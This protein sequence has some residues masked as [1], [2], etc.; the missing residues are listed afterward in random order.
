MLNFQERNSKERLKGNRNLIWFHLK[1]CYFKLNM[2]RHYILQSNCPRMRKPRVNQVARSG[3]SRAGTRT[4]QVAE[5]TFEPGTGPK[6][7]NRRSPQE[8]RAHLA[9]WEVSFRPQE[10]FPVSVFWSL[11]IA[12]DTVR[13]DSGIHIT[14][15]H[16]NPVLRTG[17]VLTMF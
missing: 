13:T 7:S 12:L 5:P 17:P 15:S 11:Q 16:R 6:A 14:L 2:P 4:S 3:G 8:S 10:P 9:F 1:M